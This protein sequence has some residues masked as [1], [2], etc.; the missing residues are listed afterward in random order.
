MGGSFNTSL[1]LLLEVDLIAL[2]PPQRQPPP[3]FPLPAPP[4]LLFLDVLPMI[5]VLLPSCSQSVCCSESLREHEF[6]HVSVIFILLAFCR[7]RRKGK[8]SGDKFESSSR[9]MY[10][11]AVY[12]ATFIEGVLE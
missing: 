7:L 1:L 12:K 5:I 11:R 3:L 6:N 10:G 9:M 2:T 4:P 8:E